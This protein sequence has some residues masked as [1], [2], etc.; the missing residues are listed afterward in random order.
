[1]RITIRE[2]E[3]GRLSEERLAQ[4][5]RTFRD[6]GV[7]VLEDVY[8]PEFIAE[9]RAACE[10]ELDRYIAARGGL[11]ALEG[12]TFGKH[13]IGFFPPLTLPLADPRIA[14]PPLAVQIM[15]ALLGPDLQCSFYHTNTALPGSGMQSVHRDSGSLF[16]VE[17]SLPH[18]VTALVLNIPLCDFTEE[19]GS[20]EYWPGTHLIVDTAPEEA[21][22]LEARA[23][24]MASR[25]LNMPVGSF[26]LRDLRV[27]HRG[28]PNAADYPRTMFAIVYQR[29]WLASRPITIPQSTW[30]A[31]P[32]TARHIFRRNTVVPDEEHRPLTWEELASRP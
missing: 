31:W 6:A 29:G 13:H 1:M 3:E 24:I 16:G 15:T 11:D 18:P 17:M 21:K 27:W 4:A 22:A 2:R 14:A 9:V 8:D 25:R 23:E 28:M 12:K 19:N 26:A 32:E 10:T 5:V 30:K 20:T 7:V